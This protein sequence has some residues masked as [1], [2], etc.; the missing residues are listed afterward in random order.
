MGW[1]C[2]PRYGNMLLFRASVVAD[3]VEAS[4]NPWKAGFVSIDDGVKI[5]S[6]PG[7]ASSPVLRTSGWCK[8]LMGIAC[9]EIQSAPL[10]IRMAKCVPIHGEG[11]TKLKSPK[12][13]YGAPAK[14]ACC[15]YD[16]SYHS[17]LKPLHHCSAVQLVCD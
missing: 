11:V 13:G 2:T 16:G 5:L 8:C 12:R 6:I 14:P 15:V 10:D 4:T 7:C 17:L 9:R 1:C 3:S